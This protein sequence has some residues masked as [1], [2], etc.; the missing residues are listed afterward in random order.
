MLP[1]WLGCHATRGGHGQRWQGFPVAVNAVATVRALAG[2]HAP[3]GLGIGV[4]KGY[5]GA[6]LPGGTGNSATHCPGANDARSD[7][8]QIP[9]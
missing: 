6:V 5:T 2:N 4:K 8:D 3:G 9:I 1:S 7:Q